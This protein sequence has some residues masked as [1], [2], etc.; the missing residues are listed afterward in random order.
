MGTPSVPRQKLVLELGVL[1]WAGER[2]TRRWGWR[3]GIIILIIAL[4]NE[5]TFARLWLWCTVCGLKRLLTNLCICIY[6]PPSRLVA[7]VVVLAGNP[8]PARG[9]SQPESR[10]GNDISG[11]PRTGL[12]AWECA[13]ACLHVFRVL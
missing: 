10:G 4:L 8:G 5:V 12:R 9:M 1:G 3:W 2:A 13:K 6:L 11:S 7:L